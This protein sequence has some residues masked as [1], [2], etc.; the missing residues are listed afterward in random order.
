MLSE[1]GLLKA[2]CHVIQAT[3]VPEV[4]IA[5]N[6]INETIDNLQK[7]I[8]LLLPK[9]VGNPQWQSKLRAIGQQLELAQDTFQEAEAD[10]KERQVKYTPPQLEKISDFL[11]R[12][13][14]LDSY[15]A[16]VANLNTNLAGASGVVDGLLAEVAGVWARLRSWANGVNGAVNRGGA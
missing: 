13:D 7:E 15:E 6:G 11:D 5:F 10:F 12:T 2:L 1:A 8:K 4:L 9:L 14:S 3:T 16:M